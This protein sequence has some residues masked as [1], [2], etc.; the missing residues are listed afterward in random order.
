MELFYT[1]LDVITSG[2]LAP[3]SRI[4]IIFQEVLIDSPFIGT[5]FGSIITTDM[6]FLEIFCMAGT[7]GLLIYLFIF[8]IIFNRTKAP[9]IKKKK[10]KIFL[11]FIWIILLISS[12][13]GSS[14]TANRISIFI[15]I[16]TT[17]LLLSINQNHFK[18]RL[19]KKF[20]ILRNEDYE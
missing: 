4:P 15:W 20:R 17:L 13:G 10:E 3:T 6:G 11:Y 5:G 18:L 12:I 9:R 8:F 14:I 2:R 16:I 7:F 19:F 1:L